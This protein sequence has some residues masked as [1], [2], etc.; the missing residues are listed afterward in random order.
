MS[1]K[2]VAAALALGE[3]VRKLMA[4]FGV[5]QPTLARLKKSDYP[6]AEWLFEQ[7]WCVFESDCSGGLTRVIEALEM[8]KAANGNVAAYD[9][10]FYSI[11]EGATVDGAAKEMVQSLGTDTEVLDRIKAMRQYAASVA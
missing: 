2:D 11:W 5:A 3:S 9:F 6:G 8:L 7:V 4:D 1:V 10:R